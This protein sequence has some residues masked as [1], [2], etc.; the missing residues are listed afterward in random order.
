MRAAM[1]ATGLSDFGNDY[2]EKPLEV[3]LKSIQEEANLHPIGRFITRQR[4][5]NL[6]SVRLRAEEYFKKYPEILEQE[7]L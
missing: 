5:I 4:I 7:L 3:M 1:K 6:L 2:W